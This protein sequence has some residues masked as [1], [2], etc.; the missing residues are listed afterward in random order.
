MPQ[1]LLTLTLLSLA[2]ATGARDAVA[3]G[4][5][6]SHPAAVL[7]HPLDFQV[8]LRAEG[9]EVPAPAC[10]SAEVTVGDNVLPRSSVGASLETV[11]GVHSVRVR[12]SVRI[13]EPVVQVLV[14]AGCDA[15]VSRR[16][17]LFADPPGDII[18][19]VAAPVA[20]VETAALPLVAGAEAAVPG[21]PVQVS[22][23]QVEAPVY[24]AAAAAPPADPPRADESVRA[25]PAPKVARARPV[26]KPAPRALPRPALAKTEAPRLRL[27]PPGTAS[28]LL[29][30]AAL[31]AA[32]RE[33][34]LQAAEQ[35]A[36]AAQ[37]SAASAAARVAALEAGLEAV[38]RD[39][40]AQREQL[41][42]MGQALDEAQSQSR[43]EPLWWA[44]VAALLLIAGGL[45]HQLRSARAERNRSWW[46]EHRSGAEAEVAYT[47]PAAAVLAEGPPPVAVAAAAAQPQ[48]VVEPDWMHELPAERTVAL[49]GPPVRDVSIDEL[50]DLEQQAEFFI[51]LGQD[52][53]AIE[54]LDEHLRASGDTSPLP[55]LKLMDIY[56]RVGNE[57]AY[58]RTRDQ[59]NHRFNAIAPAWIADVRAGRTLESYPD[60]VAQLQRSWPRPT[61]AM[62]E[63]ETLLF[64][65]DGHQLFEL[66]AYREVLFL[67][68]LARD[69]CGQGEPDSAEIDV[70]LPLNVFDAHLDRRQTG[71]IDFDLGETP[72]L[73][74]GTRASQFGFFEETSTRAG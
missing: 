28:A 32:E 43:R 40:Q 7:G 58:G 29:A 51:V 49:A 6:R 11:A 15:K 74:V 21:A 16:F 46:D 33:A 14:T 70:L 60:V 44:A 41:L 66:P 13:D 3:L 12:T 31:V 30:G 71:P 24:A 72:A 47:D 1:R 38:K 23:P 27:D 17:T 64:R 18:A 69:R 54:L 45:W 68:A 65:S 56:R 53:A 26:R 22:P 63:L 57:A 5:G 36:S 19:A 20:L 35:A 50:L 39:A 73:P 62:G 8:A 42:R 61:A 2:A 52:D 67:Y 37:A 10:V 55:Y 4:F 34:A 9:N 59:F 25:A 48:P